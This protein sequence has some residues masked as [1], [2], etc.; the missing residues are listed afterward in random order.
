M[1]D[2]VWSMS[3]S[4]PLF[5][6]TRYLREIDWTFSQRHPSSVTAWLP[7][8]VPV[9]S[10]IG[11]SILQQSSHV[12]IPDVS[13]RDQDACRSTVS[14]DSSNLIDIEQQSVDSPDVSIVSMAKSTI[15]QQSFS[16]RQTTGRISGQTLSLEWIAKTEPWACAS[17]LH[18]RYS[19]SS[20]ARWR[21]SQACNRPHREWW[22]GRFDLT[23]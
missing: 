2:T 23:S 4:S 13:T 12:D 11:R 15:R 18:G 6:F 8:I 5:P 16:S 14:W 10:F 1:V 9:L 3:L 21:I 20:V 22:T 7:S 19:C 17:S